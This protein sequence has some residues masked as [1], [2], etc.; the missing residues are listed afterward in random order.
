MN[1]KKDVVVGNDCGDPACYSKHTAKQGQLSG[2]CTGAGSSR[3]GLV[4]TGER[5][6]SLP[7]SLTLCPSFLQIQTSKLCL[8]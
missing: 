1:V 2:Y 6:C 4:V 8:G 7:Q 3:G 5:G